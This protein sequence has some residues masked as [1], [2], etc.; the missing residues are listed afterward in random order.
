MRYEAPSEAVTAAVDFVA[1]EPGGRYAAVITGEFGANEIQSIPGRL[2]AVSS[3]AETGQV[4][5]SL[6]TQEIARGTLGTDYS[7]RLLGSAHTVHR[8][9]RTGQVERLYFVDHQAL[10]A[11][12]S[13]AAS[14]THPHR[15]T[16]FFGRRRELEQL[17]AQIDLARLVTVLGSTGAGKSSLLHRFGAE[18]GE[19]FPDGIAHIDLSPL[20]QMALVAPTIT[21]VLDAS[22]LPGEDHLDAV[23]AHLS[24]RRFLLMLDNVE[25]VLAETSRIVSAI[26]SACPEVA[27]VV[28]SQRPLRLPSEARLRIPGLEVPTG[29]PD[30]RS[31]QE[32]DAVALFVDRAQLL[33]PRYR[34]N[35]QDAPTI[36]AICR[37]LD[38][39]PLAIEL[40]AAKI[41]TFSP[42]QILTRLNDRLLLLTDPAPSRP[43]RQR[44]L[45][46]SLDWAYGLLSDNAKT[47]LRRVSVFAGGFSTDQALAVCCDERLPETQAIEAFEE[48]VDVSLAVSL[49]SNV[50]EKRFRL[51][52]S[53]RLYAARLHHQGDAAGKFEA[54][55]REWCAGL[56]MEA[57]GGLAG[58]DQILWLER[59]DAHMDDV[60]EL[61]EHHCSV[62]GDGG[63]AIRSLIS[64]YNYFF[65]RHY[66]M[67]GFRLASRVVD[68]RTCK[69]IPD[70][71]RVENLASILAGRL[72]DFDAAREYGLRSAWTA[73]GQGDKQGVAKARLSL[74][75]CYEDLGRFAKAHRHAKWA[76]DVF[77]RSGAETSLIKALIN[78][79]GIEP[80]LGLLADAQQHLAEAARRLERNPNSALEAYLRQNSAHVAL[81]MG[82]PGE[83][84]PLVAS[85]LATFVEAQDLFAV[86][87]SL[88]NAAHALESIGEFALAS[89]FCGANR[90][91]M[92]DLEQR[93]RPHE[94]NALERLTE[95]LRRAL[96]NEAHDREIFLGSESSME[97]LIAYLHEL[98][99]I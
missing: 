7:F 84:L 6:A 65:L 44:S 81:A 54:R 4:V 37:K 27:L 68:A 51:N 64:V 67:D 45:K 63:V 95:R 53:V 71:S 74:G 83:A 46:A 56:C 40:A 48:L 66:L 98:S 55:H 87:T 35:D 16:A 78:L 58:S 42:R 79:A 70:L 85:A 49:P 20:D 36:A 97:G 34:M 88:R 22:K 15:A 96:G 41:S 31:A 91:L 76:V 17:G 80:Y 8:E 2:Q 18:A 3:F 62:G 50:V 86:C 57:A 26:L 30:W 14:L 24:R 23:L 75:A 73:R 92:H 61:I 82:R 13:T 94:A 77:R 21:R 32:F 90:K 25:H 33:E 28:G 89:R 11:R 29:E 99:G 9:T 69:G 47:L 59:L 19:R 60:R 12:F 52:E 1:E 38:G 72:G 93:L 5:V 43:V 10:P 39:N